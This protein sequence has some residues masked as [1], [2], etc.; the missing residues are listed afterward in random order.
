M[1]ESETFTLKNGAVEVKPLV[2]ITMLR[3]KAL[4]KN[5]PMLF[6]ELIMRAR[7]PDHA[8]F[9]LTESDLKKE[10]LIEPDGTFCDSIRNII[11]SATEGEGMDITLGSPVRHG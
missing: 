9:G 2:A 6:F 8:W 11:L 4:W 7:N 10:G 3:L 5:T 1:S